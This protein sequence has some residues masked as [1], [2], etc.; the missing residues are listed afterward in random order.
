M[1]YREIIKKLFDSD[2]TSYR[3]A[4][5]IGT[6]AQAIDNY[7]KKGAKI[8]NMRLELAEKLVQYAKHLE[9]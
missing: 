8:G 1:E 4:K 7:R 5:D 9:K 2:I 6:T 3:M